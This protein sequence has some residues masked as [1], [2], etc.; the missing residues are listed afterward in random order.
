MRK[1]NMQKRTEQ[2]V[3]VAR[4]LYDT[5]RKSQQQERSVPPPDTP[6]T[7]SD[8]PPLPGHLPRARVVQVIDGDTLDVQ[9]DGRTLRLRIIGI[10]AP[11]VQG[12]Y[13]QA[14]HF[15]RQASAR[16]KALLNG[17]TVLL[18]ADPSQ[19]EHDQYERLL[20]HLWLADGRLFSLEMLAQGYAFK[21]WTAQPHK[22]VRWFQQ[23]EREARAARRGV[24]QHHK[25]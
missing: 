9:Q 4:W 2:V 17:Q 15:G 22:Y 19:G 6:P 23:A 11:E 24:W 18:E 1:S 10:N 25:P 8:Y 21:Y 13:R 5:W 12:P 14:E 16:A 7:P 20:R 3:R